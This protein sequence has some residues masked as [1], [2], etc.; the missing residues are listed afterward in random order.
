MFKKG[1]FIKG[2]LRSEDYEYANSLMLIGSVDEV[3]YEDTTMLV[4]VIKHASDD[5]TGEEN[6][7]GQQEEVEMC[8]FELLNTIPTSIYYQQSATSGVQFVNM[9]N[10]LPISL[11][12]G[13]SGLIS[14]H[15]ISE[16]YTKAVALGIM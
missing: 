11:L 3:Y 6:Y 7:E 10:T 8:D 16:A 12:D 15:S 13:V 4:T 1:D 5:A 14:H 9:Q 2:T